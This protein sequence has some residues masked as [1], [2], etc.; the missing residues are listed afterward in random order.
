MPHDLH[1][2][3]TLLAATRTAQARAR[4][5]VVLWLTARALA[6]VAVVG[7]SRRTACAWPT[8]TRAAEERA[9]VLFGRAGTRRT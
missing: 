7:S 3:S 8:K 6:N 2:D 5:T 4:V 9:F 1:L